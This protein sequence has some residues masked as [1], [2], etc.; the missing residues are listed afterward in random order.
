MTK[1]NSQVAN[2]D[3]SRTLTFGALDENDVLTIKEM[4]AKDLTESEFKLFMLQA[5]A[6]DANPLTQETWPVAYTS[7]KTGKRTLTI[8]Y[9]V[10]L[11]E[12]KAKEF[13]NYGGVFVN[14]VH[15]NDEFEMEYVPNEMGV[16]VPRIVKHKIGNNPG[17]I[18]MGYGFAVDKNLD[19]PYS[20]VMTIS[21]VQ[22]YW[23]PN[24][25]SGG[26]RDM[27]LNNLRDMFTKHIKKRL[28]KS[29]FGLSVPG[30][31]DEGQTF[32]MKDMGEIVPDAPADDMQIPSMDDMDIPEDPKVEIINP[33]KADT[34]KEETK[35]TNE[36]GRLRSE[37]YD[38]FNALKIIGKENTEKYMVEAIPGF[39]AGDKPT[40]AQLKQLI[41]S[42]DGDIEDME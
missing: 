16:P 3:L 7:Q 30:E 40:V 12:R 15:E 20:I 24:N 34:K 14:L 37:V 25:K 2:I 27:W 21:D 32:Q 18:V 33:P 8:H 29:A 28:L 36:Y 38:K 13:Q 35:S 17:K 9:A 4:I 6:M 23:D 31:N 26:Q 19:V 22:H 11:Y 5:K 1:N 39:K 42:L 41:V 10:A